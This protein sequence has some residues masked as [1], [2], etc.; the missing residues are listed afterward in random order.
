MATHCVLGSLHFPYVHGLCYLQP[1]A[2]EY[3]K[4]IIP[5]YGLATRA[6][7]ILLST[8]VLGAAKIFAQGK[9][10][11][12]WCDHLTVV[13]FRMVSQLPLQVI[14]VYSYAG[15]TPI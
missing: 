7:I 5:W 6:N 10:C 15:N 12:I 1:G 8:D 3:T 13:H 2:L 4:T 11:T 9:V 14:F